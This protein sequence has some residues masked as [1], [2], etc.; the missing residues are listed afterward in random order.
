MVHIFRPILE[1]S[2]ICAQSPSLPPLWLPCL[3]C[4]YSQGSSFSTF[5]SKIIYS[6]VLLFARV[7]LESDYFC[8]HQGGFFLNLQF[9]RIFVRI[10]THMVHTHP[11]SKIISILPKLFL[12][13]VS[14]EITRTICSNSERSEQFLVTECFFKL[15]FLRSN[16][17][18][19]R[20]RIQ[21][22]KN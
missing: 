14:F 5:I 1:I 17:F 3:P 21:I 15:R 9:A 19:I 2:G 18:R 6:Q 4:R 11:S 22:G 13:T 12:P 7:P 10:R 16:R 8:K 20:I